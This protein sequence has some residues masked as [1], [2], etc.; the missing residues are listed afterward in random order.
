[1]VPLDGEV[2]EGVG[3]LGSPSFEIPR[4][5]E[6]DSRFD[7]LREGDELHRRLAAKNR[8]NLRTMGVFLFVRWLHSFA[9]TVLGF[10][11]LD[12]HGMHGI[13]AVALI[14]VSPVVGLALTAG[15]YVLVERL[16]Q[17]FRPLVP[18]LLLHLRAATSGG[19]SA[20]GRCPTPISTCSTGRR[21]RAWSGGCW[22][23]GSGA[24]SSTTAATSPSARSPPSAD[25]CTLNALSKIQS[26]LAGGRH[27]QVRPHHDR[28]RLHARDRR[29]RPLRGVDGRRRGARRR[30]PS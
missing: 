16:I 15:Y 23:C 17:R 27:L 28:R 29:A 20:C 19:T 8:Y 22:A 3:L 14:G 30:T 13:P 11:A 6:R 2:R 7:H 10:A 1:M 5:V 12:L 18:R 9:L 4:S 24:G 25:D 26:P 21:S